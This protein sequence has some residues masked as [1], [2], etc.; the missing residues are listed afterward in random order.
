LPSRQARAALVRTGVRLGLIP[1]A[2]A[3]R[4]R[5]YFERRAPYLGAG[6]LAGADDLAALLDLNG[7]GNGPR[8]T[9]ARLQDLCRFDFTTRIPDDLLVRTDRATMGA[10]I[11]A[12]VPFLDHDLVELVNRLPSVARML[13]GISKTAP[14]LLARRWGVPQ[15]T[16]LH[17]KIGFQLPLAA[18]FRGPLRGFWEVVLRE[19]AVPGIRYDEV[20]RLFDA[21]TSGRGEHEE[22]LWRVA[23]LESWHRRWVRGESSDGP[24]DA[25]RTTPITLHRATAPAY[26]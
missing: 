14:R 25:V 15:E 3:P 4:V 22:M 16:I 12:R 10:S 24:R 8:A 26:Q 13:P 9:G 17:R 19:R 2:D 6:A 18:W 21:H 7:N 20:A 23:A 11:E 1:A 5:E